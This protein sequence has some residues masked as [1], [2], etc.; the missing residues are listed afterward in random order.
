MNKMET[1][2]QTVAKLW[3]FYEELQEIVYVLDMDTCELVYMNRHAREIYNVSSL[4]DVKG[5]KCFE[6]LKGRTVPCAICEDN[7]LRPGHFV[8]EVRYSPVLRKKMAFKETVIE[9]NGKRYRFEM[10]VDLSAWEQQNKGYEA[11]EVMINEGLRI[12]LAAPTPEES[13]AALLEYLG[14]SLMSERVYIFEETD[15]GTFN[16]TYEWCVEGVEPQKG[17]LQGVSKEEIECRI[18]NLKKE[19]KTSNAHMAMGCVWRESGDEDIDQLMK[20]ADDLMY[21][22]KRAW[23]TKQSES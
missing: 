7:R 14:L 8:E 6:T 2:K 23:Y 17:N 13:I 20:E 1:S 11:N 4:E 15:M 12:S 9:D 3:E 21:E 22:D 16:N 5:R 18:E 19:M 10:A